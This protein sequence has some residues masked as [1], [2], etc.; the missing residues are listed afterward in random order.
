MFLLIAVEDNIQKQPI[1]SVLQNRCPWKVCNIDRK[2]T[3]LEK[4]LQHRC[5]P[6]NTARFLR[7]VFFIKHLQV[8]RHLHYSLILL[9]L[10]FSCS[11]F[12]LLCSPIAKEWHVCFFLLFYI[13]N[14]N[15]H[16]YSKKKKK[17]KKSGNTNKNSTC[18]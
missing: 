15:D 9:F 17:K 5:F 1:A 7:T 13:F 10:N 8:S 18:F 6:L 4:R 11:S 16:T 14:K 3:L 12:F 2:T